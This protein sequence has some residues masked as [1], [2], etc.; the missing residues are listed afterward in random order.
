MT[1]REEPPLSA[2]NLCRKE[3]KPVSKDTCRWQTVLFPHHILEDQELILPQK[4]AIQ[5]RIPNCNGYQIPW[6]I[7]IVHDRWP[8]SFWIH[9]STGGNRM[10]RRGVNKNTSRRFCNNSG[11]PR[12]CWTPPGD[13]ST[14]S[15][16][17]STN[18]NAVACFHC[19][20][21]FDG[22]VHSEEAVYASDSDRKTAWRIRW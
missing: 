3:H 14:T 8:L 13:G 10:M 17:M 6:Q 22:T 4:L 12:C 18:R 19:G 15:F 21:S 1:I 16:C 2:P 11:D 20:S 7:M 5:K 9:S